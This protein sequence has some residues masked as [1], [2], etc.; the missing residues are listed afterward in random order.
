MTVRAV[1]QRT[2][3]SSQV[4]YTR[5]GDKAGLLE[6]VYRD[7]FA[8]LGRSLDDAAP[9]SSG[10]D[11]VVALVGAYRRFA[12]ADPHRY[13][14]LFGDQVR[15]SPEAKAEALAALHQT[16]QAM[17][18]AVPTADAASTATLLWGAMHGPID[19]ELH[20]HLDAAH[21]QAHLEA[22]VR[23]LLAGLRSRS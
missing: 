21:A 11:L 17:A 20:G 18:D 2:G 15:P 22:T 6:A 14:L 13:R 4:V 19:L 5:F 3:A 7:A 9:G 12:L 10:D 1:A 16:M 8:E 23:A